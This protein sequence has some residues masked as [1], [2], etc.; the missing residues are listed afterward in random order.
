MR[1]LDNY[2]N[3]LTKGGNP[4]LAEAVKDTVDKITPGSKN[5]TV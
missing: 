2:L 4:A 3:H 1:Y 5:K